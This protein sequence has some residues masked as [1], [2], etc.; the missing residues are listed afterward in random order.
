MITKK[1][2]EKVYNKYLP[3]NFIKFVFKHYGK[4]DEK[5]SS[6]KLKLTDKIA[7]YILLPM[8]V[9][10]ILFTAFKVPHK[11][12]GFVA[13]PTSIILAVMVLVGMTGV[14][15]NN[16]RIRKIAKELGLSLREYNKLVEKL[17]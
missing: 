14:W 12:I 9:L 16:F 7:W 4:D 13:I 15:M 5:T 1:Q 11:I 10:G 8:I 2:F 6:I 3:N 17:F